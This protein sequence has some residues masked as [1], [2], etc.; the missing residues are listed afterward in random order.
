MSE[1][2]R[3]LH[4][5]GG[6][7]VG[8]VETLIMNIYRRIDKRKIQFDFAVEE[9]NTCFYDEEILSMGGRIYSHP[10][11]SKFGIKSYVMALRR[12]LSE[13]GAFSCV[14]SHV[15]FFSGII[16][17][18]ARKNGVPLRIAHSHTSHSA[19]NNKLL[20]KL[21]SSYM[22]RLI[23]HNATHLFACSNLAG[24]S[25]F[26]E[27]FNF[28]I[29]PNVI[30]LEQY[31]D[32]LYDHTELR[33]KYGFPEDAMIIGHVGRFDPPKNHKFLINIF[34]KVL[35]EVPNAHLLLIGD[36][37]LKNQIN[38][39]VNLL[40]LESRVHFWGIRRDVP[41]LLN[42]LDLFLFPSLYEGL[43]TV[44]IEAQAVGVPCVV[45]DGITPEVDLGLHLVHFLSLDSKPEVW[46]TTMLKAQKVSAPSRWENRRLTLKRS[47]YDVDDAV[48]FL[49]NLYSS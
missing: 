5:V 18:T 30:S 16:L 28:L 26:G 10:K 14:H 48:K 19:D 37:P 11:P 33:K 9:E 41:K 4:C 35:D 45:S 43:G 40:K 2:I 39:M 46:V 36:G 12:T 25:L 49:T 20:R 44:L 1:P 22:R 23:H 21:Y 31:N 32:A 3:I 34:R 24:R 6:M 15:H 17:R 42:I 47:G 38:E 13:N 7:N 27:N 8:G 29:L